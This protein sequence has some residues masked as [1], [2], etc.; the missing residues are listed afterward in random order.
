[1]FG[2]PALAQTPEAS[3]AS[4]PAPVTLS[5]LQEGVT[6]QYSPDPTINPADNPDTFSIITVHIFRFDT[7][8]HAAA[9]WQS[10]RESAVQ[11]FQPAG[12]AGYE[13]IDVQEAEIED[14]GDQAYAAWLSASPQEGGTAHYR[15]LYVQD[16][17]YLYLLTALGGNE[18]ATLRTDEL[19]RVIVDREPGSDDVSF[20]ADGTSTGGLWDL[21]PPADDDVLENLFPVQDREVTVP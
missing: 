8:Q 14:L 18:D 4:T 10:L 16:G 3:P 7:G 5:G 11:Q 21:F 1:M 13:E 9:T 20:N 6:R 17:E 19:A 12:D 2:A 15:V